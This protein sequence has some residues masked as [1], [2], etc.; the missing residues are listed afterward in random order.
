MREVVGLAGVPVIV[1]LVEAFKLF[2]PDEERVYPVVAI[3]FGL[4]INVGLAWSMIGD[5]RLAV[6]YGVVAGLAA[7]GL[8]SGG[9]AVGGS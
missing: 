1:G 9:K 5:L 8:Y 4:A 7:A 3:G 2:W 6:V